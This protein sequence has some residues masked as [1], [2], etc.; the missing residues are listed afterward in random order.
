MAP[1][2]KAGVLLGAG[3]RFVHPTHG[4]CEVLPKGEWTFEVPGRTTL[5]AHVYFHV[6]SMD[7]PEAARSDPDVWDETKGIFH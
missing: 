2:R 4:E 6:L 5:E 3:V 7:V 1:K